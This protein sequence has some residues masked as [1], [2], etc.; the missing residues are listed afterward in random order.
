M[1]STF[2]QLQSE[3]H[4]LTQTSSSDTSVNTFL[5]RELNNAQRL[6]YAKLREFISQK[7][8]TATT[9][10]DQQY[11]YL[12]IDCKHVE[13]ITVT[14]NSVIYNLTPIDDVNYWNEINALDFTGSAIPIHFFRRRDDFGIWPKPQGAY[15]LTIT[16]NY[17]LKDMTAEDYTT[18]T[19]AVTSGDIDVTG[20][21]TTFTAAMVGRWLKVNDDGYWYEVAEYTSGTAL[22]LNNYFQGTTGTGLSYTLGESPYIPEEAHELLAYRAAE[23]WFAMKKKDMETAQY[24]D[25]YF[26]TG[27]YNNDKRDLTSDI[28]GGL[29]GLI[30]E[31]SSRSNSGVIYRRPKRDFMVDKLWATSISS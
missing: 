31:Y 26:W 21:G 29:L 22:E 3:A 14:L 25:N 18:G 10:A 11:Y 28:F 15:T 16:Y 4:N 8:A 5:K 19:V 20:S 7:T 2:T 17:N 9:V 1:R 12:P 24:M 23:K 27:D 30:K 6:V 13:S